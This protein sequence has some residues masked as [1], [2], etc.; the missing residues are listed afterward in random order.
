MASCSDDILLNGMNGNRT[1]EG[2]QCLL[3][4]RLGGVSILV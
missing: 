3:V 2:K 1:E 4:D